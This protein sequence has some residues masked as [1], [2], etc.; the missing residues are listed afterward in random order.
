MFAMEVVISEYIVAG[1]MPVMLAAVSAAL[2]AL[3]AVVAEVSAAAI[4]S[5]W[6]LAPLLRKTWSG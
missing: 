2:S 5:Q 4:V 6:A 1:F 3:S